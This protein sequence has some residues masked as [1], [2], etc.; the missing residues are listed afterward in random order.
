MIAGDWLI[1]KASYSPN[2]KGV[3]TFYQSRSENPL[4]ISV[5]TK[6]GDSLAKSIEILQ[7]LRTS[8][9]L[10]TVKLRL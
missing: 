3:S 5:S 9:S 4:F 10:Y 8:S 7:D 6:N 1:P 2:M